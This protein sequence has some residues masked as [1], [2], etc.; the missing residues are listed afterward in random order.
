MP[1]LHFGM[2]GMIQ[3]EGQEPTWYQ[4]RPKDVV[5]EWPP[6]FCKFVLH[7][8]SDKDSTVTKLAFRDARRLGRIRLCAS[9]TEEPPISTLGFDPLLCMPSVEDFSAMVRKRGIPVKALLLDQAFSAGVGNW[10]ADEILFQA[11]I[12]P[13][14]RANALSD[15]ELVLLHDKMV[16][17]CKTAVEVDAD[18]S[19]FPKEW[20]FLHRW[21]KG[22]KER[23][24]PLVLPDGTK[25]KIKWIT[26]GGRTSAVVEQVQK[27]SKSAGAEDKKRKRVKTIDDGED[28]GMREENATEEQ[29][30]EIAEKVTKRRAT[31][32]SSSKHVE[33]EV[34]EKIEVK[35][36]RTR[37]K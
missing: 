27:L 28:V 26:V 35:K 9:P 23:D 22:K 4:S 11:R 31:R 29:D 21:G 33:I 5:D 20:I 18:S 25:A 17:V 10:V 34:D 3:I 37:R 30:V 8:V 2:T 15:E 6:R 13:E 32:S 36:I 12:H 14:Q 16:Y 1:V 7:I 19:K 24:I